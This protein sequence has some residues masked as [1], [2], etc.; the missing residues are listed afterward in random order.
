MITWVRNDQGDES[1]R[2]I[3]GPKSEDQND[4]QMEE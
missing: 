3:N 1:Y 4:D 2:S